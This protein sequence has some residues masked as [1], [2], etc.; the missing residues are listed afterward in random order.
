MEDSMGRGNSGFETK[1]I[2]RLRDNAWTQILKNEPIAFLAMAA[3]VGFLVGGGVR[4]SG[5]VKILALLGQ[6]VVTELFGE[7]ARTGRTNL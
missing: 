1:A 4:R 3:A 5:S 2:S 6:I 7:S